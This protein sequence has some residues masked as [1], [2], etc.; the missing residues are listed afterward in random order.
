M[1]IQ[2]RPA[3]TFH[4][5]TP[6]DAPTVVQILMKRSARDMGP[7]FDDVDEI[8]APSRG[9]SRSRSSDRSTF[10]LEALRARHSRSRSADRRDRPVQSASTRATQI[11]LRANE[12]LLSAASRDRSRRRSSRIRVGP[13]G[14]G[15]PAARPGR[16]AVRVG[17]DALDSLKS[18]NDVKCLHVPARLRVLAPAQP[19]QTVASAIPTFR[20]ELN[21]AIDR[22]RLSSR[23]PC[24]GTA[25]PPAG[26]SGRNTGPT[27]RICR[28]F[29][30]SHASIDEARRS[31]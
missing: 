3:V 21:A 20:R 19:A 27:T 13:G 28:N 7:A 2:L 15:G 26:R 17:V 23:R 14:M 8:R 29:A 22:D 30:T 18:S 9:P 12:R 4:N 10:L 24:T 31:G 11:E 1:A 25:S 16:H 5:G 6:V